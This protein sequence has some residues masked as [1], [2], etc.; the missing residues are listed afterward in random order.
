MPGAPIFAIRTPGSD[1]FR[2]DFHS[3]RCPIYPPT[4]DKAQFAPRITIVAVRH[5]DNQTSTSVGRG[6]HFHPPPVHGRLGRH[7]SGPC[8]QLMVHIA[9]AAFA[10]P[11]AYDFRLA[12]NFRV[13]FADQF[14]SGERHGADRWDSEAQG[15]Q[16]ACRT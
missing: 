4:R 11:L 2:T 14:R 5:D 10:G 9:V 13:C 7:G 6:H 12:H 1:F 8:T 16:R 15:G 3:R